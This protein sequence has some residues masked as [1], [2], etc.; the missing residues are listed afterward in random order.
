MAR[1]DERESNIQ[2]NTPM[3]MRRVWVVE[4]KKSCASPS[5]GCEKWMKKAAAVT[6]ACHLENTYNK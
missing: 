4:L 6:A 2:Q 3:E 5:G 1:L